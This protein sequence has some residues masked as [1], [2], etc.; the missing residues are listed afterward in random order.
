MAIGMLLKIIVQFL[1]YNGVAQYKILITFP[2]CQQLLYT[3]LLF[4]PFVCYHYSFYMFLAKNVNST[5]SCLSQILLPDILHNDFAR[6]KKSSNNKITF[7]SSCEQVLHQ[8]LQR[9][10]LNIVV[11]SLVTQT[12]NYVTCIEAPCMQSFDEHS[13]LSRL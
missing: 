6:Q 10:S 4:E 9:Y 2:F 5:D 3:S 7:C 13:F 11:Q 8:L 1:Q 12:L